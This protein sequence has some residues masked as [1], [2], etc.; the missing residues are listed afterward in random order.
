MVSVHTT[1]DSL[2]TV[3]TLTN[4]LRRSKTMDYIKI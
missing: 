3:K 1:N 4:V 2:D